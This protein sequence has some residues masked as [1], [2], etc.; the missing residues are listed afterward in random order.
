[1]LQTYVT[2]DRFGLCSLNGS[3]CV[4][5][6]VYFKCYMSLS[7]GQTPCLFEHYLVIIIIIIIIIIISRSNIARAFANVRMHA[8]VAS[9]TTISDPYG[10]RKLGTA[11]WIVSVVGIVI[12]VLTVIIVV[13]VVVSAA[14]EASKAVSYTYNSGSSLASSCNYYAGGSCYKYRKYYGSSA[15][16]YCTDYTSGGYCYSN[17]YIY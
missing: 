1:V 13:A 12:S 8:V 11:S 17:S 4:Y 9:N 10:A 6:H 3:K 14:N 5:E 15:Y 7:T 2:Q 16:Y